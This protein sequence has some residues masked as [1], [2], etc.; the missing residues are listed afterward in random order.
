MKIVKIVYG[1]VKMTKTIVISKIVIVRRFFICRRL[2]APVEPDVPDVVT[3][4]RFP[5]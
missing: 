4:Q 3:D 1:T 5:S 2:F